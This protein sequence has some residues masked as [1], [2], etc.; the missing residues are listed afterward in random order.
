MDFCSKRKK[1]KN[2]NVI[3][4]LSTKALENHLNSIEAVLGIKFAFNMCVT[5]TC[6]TRR[7]PHALY[8]WDRSLCVSL[9][10]FLSRILL[11]KIVYR[12]IFA[13]PK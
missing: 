8:L 5:S 13:I 3:A 2:R 1:K 10:L 12:V 11:F 9:S 7:L 6:T 4:F